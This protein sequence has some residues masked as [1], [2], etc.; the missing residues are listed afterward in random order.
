M[1]GPKDTAAVV[2]ALDELARPDRRAACIDA[3]RAVADSLSMDR[4]VDDLLAAY[5]EVRT[6]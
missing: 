5:H 1:A 4:H 3:C 2:D 6:S